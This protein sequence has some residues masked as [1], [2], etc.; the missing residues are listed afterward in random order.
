[1]RCWTTVPPVQL[2]RGTMKI[3]RADDPDYE[4]AARLIARNEPWITLRRDLEKC[5]AAVRRAGTELFVAR[6]D[7]QPLGLVL[8]AEHGLAG[9]PYIASIAVDEAARNRGIGSVLLR[10]AEERYLDSHEHIFLLVSSFNLRARR[11]YEHFGYRQVGEI[12]DYIVAGHSERI[13]HKRLA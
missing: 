13:M 10:F 5:R 3:V 7:D 9:S 11:L 6:Q 4:W 1:M 12:P 8:L 2:N